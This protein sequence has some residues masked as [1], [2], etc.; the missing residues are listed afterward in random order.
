MI[1]AAGTMQAGRM[2]LVADFDEAIGEVVGVTLFCD[3]LDDLPPSAV[4]FNGPD[5]I[6]LGRIIANELGCDD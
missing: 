4:A 1:V 5:A 6:L 2:R 3:P